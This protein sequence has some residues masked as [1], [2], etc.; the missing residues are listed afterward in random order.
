MSGIPLALDGDLLAH[1]D[2]AVKTGT[3]EAATR[4]LAARLELSESAIRAALERGTADDFERTPLYQ[5]MFALAERLEGRPL[6][7]AVVPRIALHSPKFTRSLTT[8]WFAG[9][10]DERYRRCLGRGGAL[11]G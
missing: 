4:T 2:E 3:T 10:V 1:G 9:R 5:R 11:A 7:R 8:E 6:P